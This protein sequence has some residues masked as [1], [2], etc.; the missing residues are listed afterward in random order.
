MV[1]G[2]IVSP[3]ELVDTNVFVYA[4]DSTDAGKQ[5]RALELIEELLGRGVLT[6]T[7]QVLNEFY[8]RATRINKPPALSHDA[9][10]EIV[11][12]L[13]T[14]AE[15]L[16]LTAAVRL[17]AL[18]GAGRYGIS[19]WD[20]L[21]WAAASENGVTTIYTENLPG[22]PIISDVRYINPFAGP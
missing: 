12:D 14:S 13:A 8:V 17:R 11:R 15:V 1:S 2:S 5:S 22:A 3:G 10:T 4:H 18:D 20:A 7:P 9:A 21:L 16:P 19:F 6:V